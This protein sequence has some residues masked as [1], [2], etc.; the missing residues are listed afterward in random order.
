M[1]GPEDMDE[2]EDLDEGDRYLAL[3]LR[4]LTIRVRF[5]LR[6]LTDGGWSAGLRV[7]SWPSLPLAA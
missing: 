6:V 3:F 2:S 1:I 5:D 4:L 7:V